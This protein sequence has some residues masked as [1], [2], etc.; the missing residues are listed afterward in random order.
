MNARLT[1]G[2]GRAVVAAMAV[3]ALAAC[4]QKP[5]AERPPTAGDVAVARVDGATIWASDVKRE[6]VAE[7][8][9]APGQAFPPNSP[10]FAQ[11]LEEVVDQD[12]LAAEAVRRGLDKSAPAERRLAAARQRVLADLILEAA[13]AK[14]VHED[15]VQGLYQEMVKTRDPAAP[16]L[17]LEAARPQII[18][19]L[20]YDRVKD[21][22]LDLR[23]HAAIETLTPPPAPAPA[24]PV[25]QTVKAKP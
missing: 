21:M 18:R 15:A 14:T 3:L 16:P 22:V 8:L 4:A 2:N 7:G 13:V 5:R 11:A 17:T 24:P 6:A 12:L 25:P 1:K 19:F 9:I 23:R 20:T 10:L